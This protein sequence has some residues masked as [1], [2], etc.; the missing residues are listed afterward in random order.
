V[1]A[2]IGIVES[3]HDDPVND[4][5]AREYVDCSEPRHDKWRSGVRDLSPVESDARH[6]QS[7]RNTEEL[8]D[9]F[10]PREYPAYV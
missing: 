10:L 9:D 2:H 6:A 5:E 3:R 7:S 8:I 1:A 4:A